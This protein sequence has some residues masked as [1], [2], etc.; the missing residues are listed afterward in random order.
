MEWT[1]HQRKG[2]P[3]LQ[4]Q[5]RS[6]ACN[7]LWEWIWQ[8]YLMAGRSPL[9]VKLA[10]AAKEICV[11]ATTHRLSL[12]KEHAQVHV[13]LEQRAFPSQVSTLCPTAEY[14]PGM[15]FP[16][17]HSSQCP[18]RWEKA[19]NWYQKV[20]LTAMEWTTAVNSSQ[21]C[22]T[23]IILLPMLTETQGDKQEPFTS[24]GTLRYLDSHKFS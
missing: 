16:L 7:T 13:K 15:H 8:W 20:R 5:S 10:L 22:G 11:W 1:P 3:G 14:R 21:D 19:K 6:A 12:E 17:N 2:F 18:F 23:G 4:Q 9:T 24:R